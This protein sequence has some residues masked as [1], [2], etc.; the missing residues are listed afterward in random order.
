MKTAEQSAGN[1]TQIKRFEQRQLS[2]PRKVSGE[3]PEDVIRNFSESMG[4]YDRVLSP[5]YLFAVK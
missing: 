4:L 2:E 3:F 1:L 5:A